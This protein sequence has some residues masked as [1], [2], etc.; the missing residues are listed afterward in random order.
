[1]VSS[2][3][4]Q[5]QPVF[6]E[7]SKLNEFI[8]TAFEL[9]SHTVYFC[10]E[11]VYLLRYISFVEW[12]IDWLI[13]YKY[14]CEM[15][16]SPEL[17]GPGCP[18]L[19]WNWC[20]IC[21]EFIETISINPSKQLNCAHDT[22]EETTAQVISNCYYRCTTTICLIGVGDDEIQMRNKKR[23]HKEMERRRSIEWLVEKF[24]AIDADRN[25]LPKYFANHH[26]LRQKYCKSVKVNI[27]SGTKE[28]LQEDAKVYQWL[29]EIVETYKLKIRNY[30]PHT[31]RILP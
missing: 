4:P 24:A 3:H 19:T 28:S 6:L 25:K 5:V 27:E 23:K 15:M 26:L 12:L 30:R 18:K 9:C 11:A 16:G 20:V 31:L 13:V 21:G 22:S 2:E 17:R 7:F 10:L 29:R 1:M 8:L 14:Y